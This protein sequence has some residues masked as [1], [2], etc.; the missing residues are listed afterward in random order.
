MQQ[1]QISF[2][3]ASKKIFGGSLVKGNPR[4]AR[5]LST[6]HPIHLVMRSTKATGEKSFLRK[7]HASKIEAVITKHANINGV[8]VYRYANAGNHLHLVVNLQTA[9]TSNDSFASYQA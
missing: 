6:K 4:T 5:P 3:K 9:M 8:K 2:L 7:A 1:R